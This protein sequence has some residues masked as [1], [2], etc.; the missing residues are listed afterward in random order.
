MAIPLLAATLLLGQG[1]PDFGPL[2]WSTFD[3]VRAYAAP[4]TRDLSFQSL[5][6]KPSVFEGLQTAQREDK[7]VLLWMYFGDPRGHC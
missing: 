1:G 5:D 6:W 4:S 3:S 7:P 2:S